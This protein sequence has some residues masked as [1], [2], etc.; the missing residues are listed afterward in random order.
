MRTVRTH[1]RIPVLSMAV[2]LCAGAALAQ[3]AGQ[4]V[5]LSD[6]GL[7]GGPVRI[8]ITK[9]DCSR[10][11]RHIPDADVAY[12]A[13][14]DVHGRK[15]AP[16]DLPGS[17][18]DALGQILPDV[19]EIPLTI[20]PLSGKSYATHG[21]G[22]SQAPL[23]TVRYDTL[24]GTFTYNDRPIGSSEQQELANACARRGVRP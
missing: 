15:V 24:R 16:A 1:W 10:L 7:S 2:L 21:V 20:K 12:K 22:D 5:P 9:N 11:L 18:A 17:G 19:L 13:G 6:S 8:V 4:P 14:E 23:G 3:G